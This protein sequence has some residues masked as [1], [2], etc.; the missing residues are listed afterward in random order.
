VT[1][2][3]GKAANNRDLL[4][5]YEIFAWSKRAQ[6]PL[7]TIPLQGLPFAATNSAKT[8]LLFFSKFF[9]N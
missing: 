5:L 1:T 3:T 7:T 9:R 2:A 6:A 4:Q 8:Q